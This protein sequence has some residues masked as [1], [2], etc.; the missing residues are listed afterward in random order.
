M[1]NK[2]IFLFWIMFDLSGT[3][4]QY[5]S[6]I[7]STLYNFSESH[8]HNYQEQIFFITLRNYAI[9][10]VLYASWHIECETNKNGNRTH[11]ILVPSDDAFLGMHP[12]STAMF[13]YSNF[14]LISRRKRS[15]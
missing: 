2:C 14:I 7:I 6:I 13:S 4:V 1:K 8:K 5:E 10:S 3:V 11:I 9:V 15:H 12:K